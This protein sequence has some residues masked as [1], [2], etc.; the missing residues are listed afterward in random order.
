MQR[1]FDLIRHI[2]LTTEQSN[3]PSL[4]S[5]DFA[6]NSFD[7]NSVIY[8]VYL[9]VDG[10]YLKGTD[11]SNLSD[12]IPR[13]MDLSLT[14]KGYDLLNNMRDENIYNQV[15]TSSSLSVKTLEISSFQQLLIQAIKDNA[16]AQIV[17]ANKLAK[18]SNIK[19]ILA[20]I[21][22]FISM[23][24]SFSQTNLYTELINTISQLIQEWI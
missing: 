3:Y 7:K 17:N 21:I 23:F 4:Q 15:K 10:G 19:S 6:N 13:Y 2:L 12:T 1:D 8:N 14:F 22:A 18:S 20:L 11:I 24:I 5:E 9:L 16:N